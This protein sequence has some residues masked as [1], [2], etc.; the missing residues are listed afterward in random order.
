MLFVDKQAELRN[1]ISEMFDIAGNV[2]DA[3]V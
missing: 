3:S 2:A 1:G